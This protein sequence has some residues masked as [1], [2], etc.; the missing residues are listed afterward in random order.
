MLFSKWRERRGFSCS[1]ALNGNSEFCLRDFITWQKLS[2]LRSL[3]PNSGR[4]KT[5]CGE[6][7]PL[8]S[9]IF[10]KKISPTSGLI[11][12]L[13]AGPTRLELATFCVTGRHSNQ[14]ELRSHLFNYH[15]SI[16]AAD[17]FCASFFMSFCRICAKEII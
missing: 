12:S 5:T 8:Y 4:F 3:A 7:S 14:T 2:S 6:F 16:I 11:F 1:F 17:F 15:Y 10:D 13:M 9:T